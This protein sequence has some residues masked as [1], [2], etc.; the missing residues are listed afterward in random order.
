MKLQEIIKLNILLRDTL[1]FM[2]IFI[3][4]CF[5]YIFFKLKMFK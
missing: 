2:I 4:L 3:N 1:M 5:Y